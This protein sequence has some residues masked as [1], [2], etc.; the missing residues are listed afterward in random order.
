MQAN[1]NVNSCAKPQRIHDGFLKYLAEPAARYRE[2]ELKFQEVHPSL[3][4]A[5]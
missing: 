1:P 3:Q 5:R 4:S 2:I